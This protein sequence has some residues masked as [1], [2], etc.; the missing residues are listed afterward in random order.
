MVYGNN[1]GAASTA[2]IQELPLAY[3]V[4]DLQIKY[5]LEN[6]TTTDNPS[7]GADGIVGTA[8]DDW[9]AFNLIRQVQITIKVQSTETDEK[10]KRNESLTF[11]ATY[12]TRNLG[13]DAS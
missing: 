7:V 1:R 8:D 4:E 5:V 11:S 10:T 3:N 9:Q 12:S 2:Q 13:Y 6:G